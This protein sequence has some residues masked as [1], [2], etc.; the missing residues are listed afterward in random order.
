MFKGYG[1]AR[2]ASDVVLKPVGNNK[3]VE[4]SA[5]TND[6]RGNGHFFTIQLWDSGA[7]AFAKNIQKGNLVALEF[8]LRHDRWTNKEGEAKQKQVLRVTHFVKAEPSK[9]EE[10][11]DSE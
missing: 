1:V 8:E 5:V 11:V 3:M 2:I 6:A 7:E 9:K 10:A 4:V